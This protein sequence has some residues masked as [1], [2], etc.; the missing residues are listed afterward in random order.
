MGGCGR[1]GFAVEGVGGYEGDFGAGE[2]EC[3]TFIGSEFHLPLGFP[4]LKGVEVSLEE[5]TVV[6]CLYGSIDEAVVSEESS[7]RVRSG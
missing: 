6:I 2:V 4:L 3:L 7:S 1:D 5:F